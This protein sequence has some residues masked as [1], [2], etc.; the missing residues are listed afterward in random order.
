MGGSEVNFSV[1]INSGAA[2]RAFKQGETI[3]RE[4]DPAEEFYVIRTGSVRVMSGNR[5]LGDVGESGI[6]GEMAL[7]D[8]EPRSATAIASTDVEL[9]PVGEKQFLFMVSQTP[10]FALKVMRVLATRLRTMNKAI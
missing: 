6:F 2:P 8:N 10:Y 7:V 5:K 9:I 4:G 1:L 3:F